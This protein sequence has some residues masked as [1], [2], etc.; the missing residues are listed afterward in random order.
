MG[1]GRHSSQPFLKGFIFT[2]LIILCAGGVLHKYSAQTVQKRALDF[3]DLEAQVV[4]KLPDVSAGNWPWVLCESIK[5][6]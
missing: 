5:P 2:I 4:C 3:L 1:W 6:F